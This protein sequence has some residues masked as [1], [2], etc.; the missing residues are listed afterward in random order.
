MRA[1]TPSGLV[2]AIA[3]LRSYCVLRQGFSIKSTLRQ[4]VSG[5]TT[6]I[7]VHHR[8]GADNGRWGGP[9]PRA[10]T[11]LH[12]VNLLERSRFP[13]S[14]F[15]R[16]ASMHASGRYPTRPGS[17]LFQQITMLRRLPRRLSADN[18]HGNAC[19][20]KW[21][22]GPTHLRPRRNLL[23]PDFPAKAECA[24][25]IGAALG[26]RPGAAPERAGHFRS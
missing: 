16:K 2:D 18:H 13:E 25:L 23:T 11:G 15:A 6:K 20:G 22:Q 9:H 24:D 8:R 12:A 14:R 7:L 10:G 3:H 5:A 17:L 1:F 26:L 21:N 19:P 4:D